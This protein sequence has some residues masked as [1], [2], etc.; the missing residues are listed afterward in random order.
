[1]G[2]Q[3]GRTPPGC[4]RETCHRNDEYQV[5]GENLKKSFLLRTGRKPTFT[6]KREAMTKFKEGGGDA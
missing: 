6:R 3:A 5:L 1:M 4:W 2:R